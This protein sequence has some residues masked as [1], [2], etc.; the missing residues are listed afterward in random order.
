MLGPHQRNTPSINITH[1]Q[2]GSNRPFH[3]GTQTTMNLKFINSDKIIPCCRPFRPPY[4]FSAPWPVIAV[5]PP[6][7]HAYKCRSEMRLLTC[8]QQAPGPVPLWV[9]KQKCRYSTFASCMAS[10]FCSQFEVSLRIRG[11]TEDPLSGNNSAWTELRTHWLYMAVM[12]GI[13]HLIK[14]WESYDPS[15]QHISNSIATSLLFPSKVQVIGS[16][17]SSSNPLSSFSTGFHRNV[18]SFLRRLHDRDKVV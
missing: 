5:E 10:L 4:P 16:L 8:F 11:K 1:K 3:Y 14:E 9:T 12:L 2:Q 15:M 13:L 17:K 7:H 18:H 6:R